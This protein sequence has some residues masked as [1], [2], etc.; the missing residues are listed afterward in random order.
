MLAPS[1][2]VLNVKAE[3]PSGGDGLDQAEPKS[4]A[5]VHPDD[6]LTVMPRVV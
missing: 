4:A 5:I 6:M 2:C 1:V 3:R